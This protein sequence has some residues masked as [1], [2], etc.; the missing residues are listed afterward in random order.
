LLLTILEV[1]TDINQSFDEVLKALFCNLPGSRMVAKRLYII[2]NS[3]GD[4]TFKRELPW[5]E[6]FK[7]GMKI[8]MSMVFKDRSKMSVVCPKCDTI[9]H[10]KKGVMVDW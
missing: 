10:E 4:Q 7:P 9:S 5:T 1:G 2:E 8:N 3:T 6:C